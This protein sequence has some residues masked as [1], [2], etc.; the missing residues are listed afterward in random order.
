LGCA[1]EDLR[2]VDSLLTLAVEFWSNM[3]LVL[4]HLLRRKE[5]SETL[6]TGGGDSR[7]VSPDLSCLTEYVSF[8]RVFA[9]LCEKYTQTAKADAPELFGWLSE[10]SPQPLPPSNPHDMNM[11]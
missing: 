7:G 4:D 6:L 1:L 11:M 3:E 5:A 2:R 10:S 8:W 9:Y